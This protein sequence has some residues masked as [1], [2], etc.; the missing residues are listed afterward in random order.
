MAQDR[1]DKRGV[2]I[3]GLLGGLGDLL[4]TVSDLAEKGQEFKKEMGGT[5][6]SGKDYRVQY[7]FSMRTADNGRDVKVEPFGNVKRDEQTG[8]ATVD[9]IREPMTDVFEESDHVLIVAEMPGIDREHLSVE[10]AGDVL[11][12]NAENGDKRYCKE[13]LLPRAF[14]QSAMNIACNNGVLEIRFNI[15]EQPGG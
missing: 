9:E 15:D 2:G 13:V 1:D 10:L 14:E 6:E 3:E 7:G 4:R 11:T 12:I 8:R 5:T